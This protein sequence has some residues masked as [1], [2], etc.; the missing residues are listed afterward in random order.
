MVG[1]NRYGR[2]E[3]SLFGGWRPLPRERP[4]LHAR[5]LA[6]V[7]PRHGALVTFDSPLPADLVEVLA[8]FR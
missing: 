6:F 3:A 1:D 5:Q 4:F 7:H 2:D 8:G